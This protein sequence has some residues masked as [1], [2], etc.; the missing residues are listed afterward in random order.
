MAKGVAVH[1]LICSRHDKE[2]VERAWRRT[3]FVDTLNELRFST[4]SVFARVR[5]EDIHSNILESLNTKIIGQM[6]E[7]DVYEG[8]VFDFR[9]DGA[10]SPIFV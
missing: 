10:A 7:F 2:V 3:K 8:L 6:V 9:S 5:D 4:Q 1:N